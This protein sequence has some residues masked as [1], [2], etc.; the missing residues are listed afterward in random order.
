MVR[1]WSQKPIT[2]KPHPVVMRSHIPTSLQLCNAFAQA[3]A[4]FSRANFLP[5]SQWLIVVE[6][7]QLVARLF[8]MPELA[9]GG[10]P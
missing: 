7:L 6:Q 9:A 2:D 8:A 3:F 10:Y 4:R 1:S 5:F